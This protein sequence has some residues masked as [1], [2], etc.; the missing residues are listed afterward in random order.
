MTEQLP[1]SVNFVWE[2]EA[3]IDKRITQIRSHVKQ[4]DQ[5]VN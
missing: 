2:P 4:I 3:R 5:T 1:T